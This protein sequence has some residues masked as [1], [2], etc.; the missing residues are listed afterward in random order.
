MHTVL[1]LLLNFPNRNFHYRLIN[2]EPTQK[3]EE[4]E[5][6]MYKTHNNLTFEDERQR[7]SKHAFFYYLTFPTVT[8]TIT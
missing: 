1:S 2:R 8:F 3:T 5:T 4:T 6:W 7:I